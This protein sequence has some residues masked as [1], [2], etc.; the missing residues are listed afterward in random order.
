MNLTDHGKATVRAVYENTVAN[1]IVFYG[2]DNQVLG[3]ERRAP[4]KLFVHGAQFTLPKGCAYLDVC[5]DEIGA[6]WRQNIP[7]QEEPITQ[8]RQLV[9]SMEW[10]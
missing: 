1:R 7:K 3:V 9:F 10:V 4:F 6:I 8:L 5:N 2:A